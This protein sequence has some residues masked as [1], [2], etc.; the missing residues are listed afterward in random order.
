MKKLCR[1]SSSEL[2]SQGT[3]AQPKS[4]AASALDKSNGEYREKEEPKE[5]QGQG[6]GHGN[7]KN[8]REAKGSK[9]ESKE[10]KDHDKQCGEPL[11]VICRSAEDQKEIDDKN[12]AR[13]LK[14]A[15]GR[16][17][18]SRCGALKVSHHCGWQSQHARRG[19]IDALRTERNNLNS[20]SQQLI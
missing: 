6:Q 14:I 3:R 2:S 17:K 4:R 15:R 20:T 1:A 19:N 10:L 12:E 18:C 8:N 7:R 9:K 13:L 5:G 16:Y 11:L